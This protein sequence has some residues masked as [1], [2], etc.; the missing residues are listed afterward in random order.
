[1]INHS[2]KI[3]SEIFYAPRKIFL[4]FEAN[5]A[6]W[7]LWWAGKNFIIN[8]VFCVKV[9]RSRCSIFIWKDCENNCRLKIIMACATV[10]EKAR[11]YFFIW[12]SKKIWDVSVPEE[13]LLYFANKF[14]LFGL[15]RRNQKVEHLKNSKGFNPMMFIFT[16]CYEHQHVFILL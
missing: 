15:V 2:K 14:L 16:A 12:C 10:L 1:M 13:I 9:V 6:L 4:Y 5:L 11:F 7:T 3:F 8:V